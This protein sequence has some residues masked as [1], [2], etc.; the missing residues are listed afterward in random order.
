MKKVIVTVGTTLENDLAAVADAW[1]RA[2]RGEVVQHHV[3]AFESWEALTAV[4]TPE[5]YR[6]LRHLHAHP[7]KSV[8]ALSLG[9]NR[10]YKRVHGDVTA[11]EEAGLIE[12]DDDGVR[13]TAD[14]VRVE[15][16]FAA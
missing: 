1:K 11:L 14:R 15:I 6:L 5:R 4:L 2:E 9:L 10:D 7:A 13:A 3:V 16:D 12:R 8:R